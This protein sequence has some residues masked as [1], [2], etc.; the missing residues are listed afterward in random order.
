MR[1][2]LRSADIIA[3]N[4]K[5]LICGIR[6][7]K[8]HHDDDAFPASLRTKTQI[9]ILVYISAIILYVATVQTYDVDA[10][11]AAIP[12]SVWVGVSNR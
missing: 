1:T 10:G 9:P 2:R 6:T 3:L 5:C 4:D 8:Y 7:I 11:R 12:K